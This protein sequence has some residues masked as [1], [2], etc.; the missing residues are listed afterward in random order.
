[1]FLLGIVGLLFLGEKMKS[2]PYKGFETHKEFYDYVHS[3]EPVFA[4]FRRLKNARTISEAKRCS[5]ILHRLIDVAT[6]SQIQDIEN[7]GK[8]VEFDL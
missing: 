5:D 4:V 8:Q 1:M 2:N 7:S 6:V 3:N